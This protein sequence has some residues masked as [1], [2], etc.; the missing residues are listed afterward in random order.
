MKEGEVLKTKTGMV[1]LVHWW[2]RHR[3]HNLKKKPNKPPKQTKKP[4]ILIETED[5]LEGLVLNMDSL[6]CWFLKLRNMKVT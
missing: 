5:T 6:K 4:Q 3:R 1:H 2:A